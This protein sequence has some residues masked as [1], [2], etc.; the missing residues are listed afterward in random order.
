MCGIL[1]EQDQRVIDL[2]SF[3]KTLSEINWRGPDNQGVLQANEHTFLGHCRLSIIDPTSQSDQPMVSGCGRYTIIFNGEIYNYR[4]IRKNLELNCRTNSDTEVILEGYVKIGLKILNYLD[5][6]FAFVIHDRISDHWICA[7]DPFGI[8]PLFYSSMNGRTLIC[9]EASPIARC[10][11]CKASEYAIQE[12]HLLRS[13]VPG[14][15]FFENIYQLLPG[16]YM[17]S[18]LKCRSYWSWERT[19]EKFDESELEG[20]LIDSV[21][22]HEMSDVPVVS[23]LSGG[24]DS[25]II[26]KLSDVKKSYSVGL[27]DNNEFEGAR[28]SAAESKKSLK[29]VCT[30]ANNLVQNWRY[31]TRLRGEP[32]SLPNEGLIYEVCKAMDINE[33]VVLTGE[34]ADELFFGYDRIFRWASGCAE[35]SV[36][37]FLKRYGYS[38]VNATPR[39]MDYLKSLSSDKTTIEFVE[40]FFL[41]Y[42]LPNL[43]RRMDFSAMAASKEARVPFVTKELVSYMYRQPLDFRLSSNETKVPLRNIC[44][45]LGLI[46]TLSRRKVGFDA[47]LSRDNGRRDSY[48]SFQNLV[49]G[50]LGW[51]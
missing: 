46:G 23:L 50:E 21:R 41:Q 24:I 11:A 31:L 10:F 20:L 14:Y 30:T 44:R 1:F 3:R 35:L 29:E 42:H 39:L 51:L 38:E 2:D 45:K 5:G 7:R 49:L 8:K 32:L 34:G 12:W 13:P 6:M 47:R 26:T 33:K 9:S 43:L 18:D 27:V 16:Y 22:K 15:S 17:T 28:L 19:M 48:S 36:Q 4:E 37:R 40:D 25:A